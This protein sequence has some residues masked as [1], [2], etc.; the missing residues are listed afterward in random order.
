MTLK[1]NGVVSLTREEVLK[2]AAV[3]RADDNKYYGLGR[4]GRKP[5]EARPYDAKGRVDCSGAVCWFLGIDR[6][7]IFKQTEYEVG[8]GGAIQK[9]DVDFWW[10]TDSIYHDAL[11]QKRMRVGWFDL[12]SPHDGIVPGD[13]LVYPDY[14]VNGQTRQ[15]HVAMVNRLLPGFKRGQPD[16]WKYVLIT[17]ATPSHR[18]KYGN[19]IAET[20]AHAFR[21]RKLADG[22]TIGGTFV[23]YTK[24]K[25]AEPVKT[26]PPKIRTVEMTSSLDPLIVKLAKAYQKGFAIN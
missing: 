25:Q 15:G 9:W 2:R 1:S 4:G 12:V 24:F 3:A 7:Q 19:V 5:S 14:R 21:A 10:S 8:S 16:W 18:S 11:W 23:R 6:L 13:L 26:D 20:N 17:H 22:Q